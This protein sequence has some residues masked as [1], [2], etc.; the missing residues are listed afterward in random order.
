MASLPLF[1]LHHRTIKNGDAIAVLRLIRSRKVGPATFHRLMAEHGSAEAALD[2]LPHMARGAGIQDYA[3]CPMGV[4]E[5]EMA[6]GHRAGAKLIAWDDPHYPPQLREIAEAPPVL[7]VKGDMTV[8]HRLPVAVVGARN[9]SS[10]GLR[11][12]RGLA[13]GLAENGAAVVAGLARGIDTVA[14]EATLTTG[15]V[16]VMAGGIDMIYPSENAGLAACICETGLLMTE[17]PPGTEPVARHF[18]AR[19]RIISGLSR[20]VVVVEA[21]HRSGSLITAKTALD[22]GREVMAVPGHPM[23]ARAAGCNALIRDGAVLVRNSA[24]VIAALAENGAMLHEQRVVS[25]AVQ[26]AA[27]PLQ[28]TAM[29]RRLVDVGRAVLPQSSKRPAQGGPIELE[30][31]ILSMLGPSPT[32]E[33]LLIRDLGLP[34]A[35]LAPAI[36]AL[37]LSGRVQRISGGKIA[38]IGD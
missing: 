38:R 5:A 7:W 22:Q 9:A 28:P 36:L 16:A 15:T 33:N 12:A 2:A 20:A 10:L 30:T 11:M 3:P 25:P 8:L 13:L 34:A 4:A 27:K 1:D 18:P 24:D 37:E 26:P 14:H 32:E 17:Q 31:R 6:A 35:T 19:N 21:A 23:D 29:A